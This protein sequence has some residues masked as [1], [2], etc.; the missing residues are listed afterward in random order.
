MNDRS[1]ARRRMDTAR[2][3]HQSVHRNTPALCPLLRQIT[4]ALAA[5]VL[6]IAGGSAY[7][8][9]A[10]S[11]SGTVKDP[12]GAT[13]TGA[14]VTATN[15][16]TG[17]AQTQKTNTAGFYS[18]QS[19]PL[20]RYDVQVEQTGFKTFRQTGLVVD[21]N[22]ALVVDAMLPVGQ[23]SEKIE[24]SSTALHVET[25]S[26]Q[27]GEVIGGNEMTAVP[28]VSRS[29]TD[30]LAL[31]PGVVSRPSGLTGAYAGTFISAGFALPQVSGD[32]NSGAQSVNGM[33]EAA[34]GFILNGSSVQETGFSGAGAIP[35][36]DSLAEFRILTNN[37]EAEYGNYSGGQINVIT[38]SGT[39]NWHGSAFEFLRNTDLD[40]ANFFE[41]GK[42]GAY[43]QNQFGGTF[44]GPIKRDKLFFFADYQGNRKVQGIPQT[45]Q[46]VPNAAELGG[47][48]SAVQGQ[49]TGKVNSG[50]PNPS[51]DLTTGSSCSFA[52]LLTNRLGYTVNPG[53]PYFATPCTPCVFPN[54]QFPIAKVDPIAANLLK[55]ILPATTIDPKG[56]TT[57][58]APS[59]KLRLNDN[60]FSG[61]VDANT[62]FGL[63]SGYYYFD[64]YTLDNPYS[65]ANQPM[66]PGFGV[67]GKGRAHVVNLGDTKTFGSAAVNELRVAFFRTNVK[68]NQP[69]GGTGITLADLGFGSGANRAPGIV[70]LAP[71]LQGIPEMDFNSFAIGVPSRPNQLVENIYQ[72]LDNFSK[73]IGTHTLKFGGQ[74]HF[75][76]VTENLVNVANGNFLFGTSG[77]NTS[78]TGIDFLDFLLGAPSQYIQ[79]QSYPSRGR[80]FYFGLYGQDSW[81]LK[82]NL[83]FNYGLRWDVSA[84]WRERYNEI[85]TL[86]PGEQ[87]LVFP[88]APL[89]W[90]FPGD[91]HVPSTLAPTR[92]NNFAP[93]LGLAYSPDS[94]TS[95]R[96]GYGIFFTA[97]EG[98][99]NFNEIG[100]APFG[101]FA[102]ETGPTNAP[103][104]ATPFI[105][106][107]TG[108][109][110]PNLFPVATPPKNFSQK[111]PANFPP[112]DTLTNWLN[113]FGTIGSSPGFFYKNRLPYAQ[114]YELS[115]ER[116]IT[117]SDLLTVSYVGTQAHR[118][119]SSLSSNPG[120]PALCLSLHD[121]TSVLPNS[122]TCGPGGEN[123][124][125]SPVTGPQVLGTRAPF[126]GVILPSGMAVT[127]FANNAWFITI[128]NS[129]YNSAQVNWRHTSG[130]AQLLLG[131]TFSHAIDNASGYG[132]Q[133]NPVNS[134]LTRGLSA[135][136]STH[137]F[138]VSYNYRLPFDKLGGFKK[139]TNGWEISGITRFSTG[140][141]VTLVETD[142]QSLLGTSFGGPITLPVDTPNFNG[143]SVGIVDP[144]KSTGRFYFNPAA[145][146]QATLGSE[147]T[148]RR[149]FFHGPGVND[150]DIAL[151]KDTHV[152]E[153]ID[154]EFR[155]EFFNI[156]NH[157]QFGQPSG[158]AG[159]FAVDPTSGLSLPTG[160]FGQVNSAAPPRIG[161]LGL[162][163]NF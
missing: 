149:R 63:L 143:G 88:G 1:A 126:G 82:S 118:L 99:T 33:R 38:K 40:A 86:I 57:F 31:Q 112:Y 11:I 16:E 50:P 34:N 147:G 107:P 23:V 55:F 123:N 48:F 74:Y 130:R 65:S 47:D 66:Y 133:I 53:E 90:V 67:T 54:A 87:S 102:A 155:A 4:L 98:A 121:P 12:S 113:A 146:S 9:V 154:L 144:R 125:Y 15:T 43:Q 73:V 148:A 128:G 132:E 13:I 39:N 131:Y 160:S 81:R 77:G 120:N 119:L 28:L 10:A 140:L 85:Q 58:L 61:R 129:A 49:L 45:L 92:W 142:D 41:G 114:N 158:I 32:L 134:R 105:V 97:F 68:L 60:K 42:R 27:L 62:G 94:K 69:K 22:A 163:L 159:S 37:F 127:P 80:D 141:P 162:K 25:A 14:T 30:L 5:F 139:L 75:N 18:F 64:N 106:R 84:P 72:V 156:F 109:V 135:F 79:G 29:Y 96:V 91:P 108:T 44:G 152:T 153:G 19:L 136:D 150:W 151:L 122:P 100:D 7:A 71:S 46:G 115:I 2:P 76:Q 3:L 124:I 145:F 104:F 26:T 101:N 24:V 116:Q 83:T 36:L 117:N 8:G 51:C 93:R 103:T 6:F 138:V 157:T 56:A 20:G 59:Q 137:N 161:Q 70:P 95:I 89:G 78:E 35:N 52:Q 110:I 111:N 17:I 21:V